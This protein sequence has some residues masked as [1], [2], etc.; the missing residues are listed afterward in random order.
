MINSEERKLLAEYVKESVPTKKIT[1]GHYQ[2]TT[3]DGRT[4]DVRRGPVGG[5]KWYGPNNES[6]KTVGGKNAAIKL[7]SLHL[8]MEKLGLTEGEDVIE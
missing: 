4:F 6:S 2:H 5:W 8:A 1:S 3:A 7:L